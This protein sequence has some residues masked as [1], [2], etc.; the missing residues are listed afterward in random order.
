MFDPGVQPSP[1]IAQEAAIPAQSET[2]EELVVTAKRFGSGLTRATFT[3]R[4]ED[5]QQRPPGAEITQ[6]LVK[7]P[8]V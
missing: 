6:A 1:A 3:L 2:I 4:V 5:I 7:V 8:G